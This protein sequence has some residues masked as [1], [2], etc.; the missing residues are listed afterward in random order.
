MTRKTTFLGKVAYEAGRG[1]VAGF[2]GTAAM[3]LSSTLESKIRKRPPS[4]VPSEVGGRLLGV[5]PRDY[6]GKQRFGNFVH[7]QYGTALGL[8]RA[9]LGTAMRDPLAGAAFFA[10]IWA[11]E[12]ALVPQLSSETPPATE[13]GR[14][15]I[16]I[17][18]WHHLVYAAATSAAFTL[19]L[20][21]RFKK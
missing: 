19:L 8:L 13:W 1:L 14:T 5:Q 17:D 4:S 10:L 12:L 7:W 11:T 16:A 2:L 18:G 15:E 3:T 20:R 21:A 9:G 6:E